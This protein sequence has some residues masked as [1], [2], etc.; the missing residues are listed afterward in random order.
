M[1]D[2]LSGNPRK[3]ELGFVPSPS[4]GALH[5]VQE[6]DVHNCYL[7]LQGYA[8]DLGSSDRIECPAL[9]TA[10]GFTQLVFGYPNEEAYWKDPRGALD[11]GFY[12]IEG[13]SWSEAIDDYNSRSFGRLYFRGSA[14][15]HFFIGSKDASC[16]LLADDLLVEP[17]PGCRFGDVVGMI[18][19]RIHSYFHRA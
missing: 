9:V 6:E 11:H 8:P 4:G 14:K 5:A 2:Y 16:Q 3:L 15:K 12:E 18:P 1:L 17:F 13:S 19:E 10:V 7:V